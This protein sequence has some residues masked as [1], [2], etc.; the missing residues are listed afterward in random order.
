MKNCLLIAIL[1]LILIRIS[2]GD[3][4]PN[5]WTACSKDDECTAGLVGCSGVWEPYN[6]KYSSEFIQKNMAQKSCPE[7]QLVSHE[8][9]TSC[10]DKVCKTI[11][12]DVWKACFKNSDCTAIFIDKCHGEPVNQEYS[13]SLYTQEGVNGCRSF[14]P[15]TACF[16]NLCKATG[17][18]TNVY[19]TGENANNS[20]ININETE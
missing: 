18:N 7:N 19:E 1:S 16:D 14:L 4:V 15:E 13:Q 9:L 3:E 8:P 2:Y 11:K 20:T 12:E 5:N 6:I 10:I 17:K